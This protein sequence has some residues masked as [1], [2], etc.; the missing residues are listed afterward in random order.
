MRCG[1]VVG[2]TVDRGGYAAGDGLAQ[3][4]GIG[5]ETVGAGIAAGTGRHAVRLVDDEKR[6]GLRRVIA[7]RAS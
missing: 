3:N 6:A 1:D 2:E 4:D 7:R 5:L